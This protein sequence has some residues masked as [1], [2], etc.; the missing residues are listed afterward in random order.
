MTLSPYI[1]PEKSTKVLTVRVTESQ[2]ATWKLTAHELGYPSLAS[3][4]RCLLDATARQDNT[5]RTVLMSREPAQV[6]D[7]TLR[8]DDGGGEFVF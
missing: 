5:V 7:A 2:L 8:F 6:E 3:M 1:S 4:V